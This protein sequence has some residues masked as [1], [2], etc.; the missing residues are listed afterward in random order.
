MNYVANTQQDQAAML[1]DIGAASVD[2]LFSD[3]PERLRLKG[4]L[5]LPEPASEM[6]VMTKFRSLAGRNSSL[7]EYKNFMG[8]GSYEHFIPSAVQAVIGRSDFYTAY[9]PY[10]PE[11]SQGTLMSIFEYQ[12]MI[13]NLTGMEVSNASHY[14]GATAFAESMIMSHNVNGRR[15]FLVAESV[16]PR[17]MTVLKTYAAAADFIIK[18]IPA[19]RHTG[20]LDA[21][22][23]K[24]NISDSTAAILVQ[25]PSYLG[26]VENFSSFSEIAHK[27]GALF[28]VSA[29]PISLGLLA[30]PS[31]YGADIVSGEGQ[32]LGIP[33]SFG[34]PNLGFMASTQ[35]QMRR[36]PGRIVGETVDKN[37]K[38]AY[39]LTLQARE[40]H[41]RREKAS[42]N[43]CSNQALC[44]L[45]ST[46]YLSYVGPYGLRDVAARC[47]DLAHYMAREI[48]K[49]RGFEVSFEGTAFFHEF[50]VKYPSS[51]TFDR[52]FDHF[53]EAKML[54]GVSLS[55]FF[56]GE[57]NQ[58]LVCATEVRTKQDIDA[59]VK[60]LG[61]LKW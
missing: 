7:S 54:P 37:G 1:H 14:D 26:V 56:P 52:I 38:K 18:I 29:N 5:K 4:L 6:E 47:S 46:V 20:K 12:T 11:I 21:E 17:Y 33:T 23:V 34:G 61:E 55:D 44:A 35:K 31:S 36:M 3:V 42:S 13:C 59:Y 15:E 28:A 60:R 41:I 39:V 40:Q 57:P 8:A 2:A 22:F 19:D 24:T 49:V 51:L 50:V 25:N 32:P 48:A 45:A 9:T 27:N 16:N 30:P 58:M 53:H 43:I 10:Q